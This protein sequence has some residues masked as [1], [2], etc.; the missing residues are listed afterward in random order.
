[1][2]I[3][4]FCSLLICLN[5]LVGCGSLSREGLAGNDRLGNTAKAVQGNLTEVATPTTIKQLNRDLEYRPQVKIIAPQ[6]QQTFNSTEI[7]VKL[8]LDN[9][10][11]FQDDKLKLG[12]HLNLILDN[13]PAQP[14]YNV[15]EIILL[16]NLTPGTHTIRVFAVRPWSESFKNEGAYAQTTFNVLTE[17]NDNRPDSA[18][19]LLTYSQPTG[20]YGAE[21]FLLD[22]YLTNAPLHAVAQSR[23]DL[24]DWSI[25]ATV[26]GESFQLENWQPVY[27][28]GLKPGENWIQLELLDEAGNNLEN[29]YNNTVRVINYDPQQSDTL[30][31]LMSDRFTVAD[32]KA[33]VEPQYYIQPVGE[34]EIIDLGEPEPAQEDL[35][36]IAPVDEPT[37]TEEAE[38]VDNEEPETRATSNILESEPT[39][40]DELGTIKAEALNQQESSPIIANRAIE[41]EVETPENKELEDTLEQNKMV[42]APETAATETKTI[43]IAP[44]K[45][46]SSE[47]VAVIEIPQ[48]ETV[49][50][51]ED[52]IAITI[53]SQEDSQPE[54][55][56]KKPGWWK[57]FLVGLRQRLEGLARLLPSQT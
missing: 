18:L 32:A 38:V 26:N 12:N 51:T 53:P 21:P 30:S 14:V 10:A 28:R 42:I 6:T 52:E 46:D 44:E 54:L 25:R 22:F 34:P 8:E 19:P 31:K 55:T 15:D 5:L 33:M 41:K 45:A 23:E 17:T 56:V 16:K 9:L 48:P 3:L 39:V 2:N 36:E 37:V 1:M 24:S 11:I 47:A 7:A 43:A 35:V 27:L 50:I 13:E 40:T 29:T 20:T 4:K 57:K 49:E